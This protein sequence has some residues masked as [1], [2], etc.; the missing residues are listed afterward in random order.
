[1]TTSSAFE[2]GPGA[3][4]GEGRPSL[5]GLLAA[6]D[7]AVDRRGVVAALRPHHRGGLA[8]EGAEDDIALDIVGDPARQGGLAGAGI[9]E[10]AEHLR[11]AGLAP[12]GDGFERRVLL[13]REPGRKVVAHG[14]RTVGGSEDRIEATLPPVF[15]PKMVPRS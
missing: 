14:Q 1:M 2:T 7:Q 5:L 4:E 9:A 11:T 6:I 12:L 15:R 13:G 3:V 8:R 10:Q